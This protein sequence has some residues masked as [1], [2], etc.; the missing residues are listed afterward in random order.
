[1]VAPSWR[2]PLTDAPILAHR[3]IA[4]PG[5]TDT[6]PPEARDIPIDPTDLAQF[7]NAAGRSLRKHLDYS[8]IRTYRPVLD[9]GPN[10]S[11]DSMADYRRWCNRNLPRWLGYASD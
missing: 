5:S 2:R 11:F 1:M 10:R 7:R 8:F 9:D 3:E 6:R 4:V